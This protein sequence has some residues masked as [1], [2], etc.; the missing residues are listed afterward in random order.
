MLSQ[1]PVTD[2]TFRLEDE[3]G[4]ALNGLKK[5]PLLASFFIACAVA[6]LDYADQELVPSFLSVVDFLRLRSLLL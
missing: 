1:S 6:T 4:C 2:T 5:K 3:M